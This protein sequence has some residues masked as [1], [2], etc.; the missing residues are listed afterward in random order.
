MVLN[1]LVRGGSASPI[2]LSQTW[3]RAGE[4]VPNISVFIMNLFIYKRNASI[5]NGIR[6]KT[7]SPSF[8]SIVSCFPIRARIFHWRKFRRKVKPGR[9]SS[10]DTLEVLY[11]ICRSAFSES[12]VNCK[13]V[14][15]LSQNSE[16]SSMFQPTN[17]TSS[18]RSLA[19][20]WTITVPSK[21]SH[22]NWSDC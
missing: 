5:Y 7:Q 10:N 4:R 11:F 1:Q 9:R 21:R 14:D 20:I 15:S 3:H 18:G 19:L 8:S 22:R 2:S 6:L 17:L 12:V 13:T 16:R